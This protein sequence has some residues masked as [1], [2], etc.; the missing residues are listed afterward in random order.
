MIKSY[1]RGMPALTSF[2]LNFSRSVANSTPWLMLV[3]IHSTGIFTQF[4]SCMCFSFSFFWPIFQFSQ[5]IMT[6]ICRICHQC[7]FLHIFSVC[8]FLFVS[9]EIILKWERRFPVWA[10][11]IPQFT[12]DIHKNIQKTK[13]V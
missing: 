6:R 10:Y 12:S 3:W 7:S 5:T 13:C 2:H 1:Q 4:Q 8:F 11:V 9:W